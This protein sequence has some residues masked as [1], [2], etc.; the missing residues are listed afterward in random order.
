MFF[1][2]ILL[3]F[4]NGNSPALFKV[5]T[6]SLTAVHTWNSP[7]ANPW[8]NAS[9]ASRFLWELQETPVGGSESR[10]GSIGSQWRSKMKSAPS[11]CHWCGMPPGSLRNAWRTL[12]RKHNFFNPITGEGCS[13][14]S[15]RP[16]LN[17]TSVLLSR[18]KKTWRHIV[19]HDRHV[20]VVHCDGK[21]ED[22]G[23][24]P[25]MRVWE[26]QMC[27]NNQPVL[28]CTFTFQQENNSQQTF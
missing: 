6:C 11:S 12:K 27:Q 2:T 28:V 26:T 25:R 21:G 9:G 24:A 13:L 7:K 8:D 22:K 4:S 16:L 19:I 23:E 20:E 15:I 5:L 10:L 3:S 17:G 18:P 14:Q 1:Y